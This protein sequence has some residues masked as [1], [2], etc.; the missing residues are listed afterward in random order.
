MGSESQLNWE[1]L[2]SFLK[3]KFYRIVSLLDL[4]S[5]PAPSWIF[6][7]HYL[8]PFHF[9]GRLCACNQVLSFGMWQ[10]LQAAVFAPG[11]S[12]VHNF[13]TERKS[14]KIA[15]DGTGY[16]GLSNVGLFA[17]HNEGVMK[18]IKAKDVEVIAYEPAL[19]EAEF[20]F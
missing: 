9:S 18:R 4:R 6:T 10:F 16:V 15:I 2:G 1:T 14:M 20:F 8:S 19:A 5:F 13:L 12:G 17:Q 11:D 3:S 7:F